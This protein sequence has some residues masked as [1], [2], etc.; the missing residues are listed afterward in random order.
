MRHSIIV[1]FEDGDTV[2][3]NINGTKDEIRAYYINNYF[4]LG[5]GSEDKAV[6]AISVEF[7]Q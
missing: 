2:A 5:S 1:T 7:Q 6:K 3:T 4:N